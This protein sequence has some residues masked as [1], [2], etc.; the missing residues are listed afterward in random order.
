M[1]EISEDNRR[2]VQVRGTNAPHKAEEIGHPFI[3]C[4][5]AVNS[6]AKD[7]LTSIMIGRAKPNID[8][9]RIG[10]KCLQ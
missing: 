3:T 7:V 10:G 6:G 1:R 9:L 5:A 2:E 4:I 8:V